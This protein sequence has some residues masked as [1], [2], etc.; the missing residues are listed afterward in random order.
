M[1]TDSL[2]PAAA[3]I[4]GE[5]KTPVLAAVDGRAAGV[6]AVADT[7]TT[8]PTTSPGSTRPKA[9]YAGSPTWSPTIP[10]RDATEAVDAEEP[11]WPGRCPIRCA[12]AS[13][14]G[15]TPSPKRMAPSNTARNFSP[16]REAKWWRSVRGRARIPAYPTAVE[17]VTAVES[18]PRLRALAEKAA[19][20]AT[21]PVKV[22]PGRAE[23]SPWRTPARTWRVMSLVR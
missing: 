3:G 17:Q 4:S 9:K 10:H 7:A 1:D 14:R 11:A 21:A 12:R 5:G 15:S 20:D 23:N 2:A 22:L 19:A 18:E 6:L 16:T 13:T 8:N